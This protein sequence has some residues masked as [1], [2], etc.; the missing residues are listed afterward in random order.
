MKKNTMYRVDKRILYIILMAELTICYSL[1]LVFQKNLFLLAILG[2]ILIFLGS[3]IFLHD[4]AIVIL[5][6]ISSYIVNFLVYNL[7]APSIL[8]Y[9]SDV[10]ISMMLIK[11]IIKIFKSTLKTNLMYVL[12]F[13]FLTCS[14]LSRKRN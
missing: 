7:G 14:I 8:I 13:I 6:L 12:I 1:D 10:F 3:Y 9:I 2:D 5:T 4:I 11:L